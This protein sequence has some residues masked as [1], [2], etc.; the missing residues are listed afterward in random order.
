MHPTSTAEI[1]GVVPGMGNRGTP[2][3]LRRGRH[4]SA[5]GRPSLLS[6]C[7]WRLA[8]VVREVR[9]ETD[10]RGGTPIGASSTESITAIPV[11][12]DVGLPSPAFNPNWLGEAA[13]IELETNR[14]VEAACDDVM[15]TSGLR[16]VK[17]EEVDEL[18]SENDEGTHPNIYATPEIRVK[19]DAASSFE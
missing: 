2:L 3:V 1:G 10:A 11:P 18:D 9:T 15:L 7:A 19:M 13:S 14:D 4:D 17:G 16:A 8:G 6:T 12:Q 5:D